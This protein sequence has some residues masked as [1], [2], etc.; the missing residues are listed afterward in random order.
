MEPP[1]AGMMRLHRTVPGRPVGRWQ[2]VLLVTGSFWVRFRP[3]ARIA[4]ITAAVHPLLLLVAFGVGV[5]MMVDASGGARVFTGTGDYLQYVSPGMLTM[6]A[7]LASVGEATYPVLAAVKYDRIYQRLIAS[8]VTPAQLVLGHLLW[9]A[10]RITFGGLVLTACIVAF[11]GARDIGI[12]SALLLGVVTALGC[13]ALTMSLAATVRNDS[14]FNPLYRFV[15][16]PMVLFSGT[17]FPISRL[18]DVIE[19]LAWVSPLW[20]GTELARASSLGGFSPFTAVHVAYLVVL[21]AVGVLVAC[22]TFRRK[23]YL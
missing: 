11:G 5:G 15:V 1:F 14:S 19:P 10:L 12:L 16:I 7:L 22:R 3:K 21:C 9:I 6:T 2:A 20:H 13:A 23:L 8:P 4:L 17:F 18:P